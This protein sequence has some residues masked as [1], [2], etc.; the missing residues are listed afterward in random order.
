MKHKTEQIAN[1][2]PPYPRGTIRA[3]AR[4]LNVSHSLV[5]RVARGLATSARVSH[6]LRQAE[7]A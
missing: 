2:R 3:I 6:A 1:R 5:S 7:A 4:R